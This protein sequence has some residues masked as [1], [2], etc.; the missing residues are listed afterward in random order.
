MLSRQWENGLVFESLLPE[1]SQD[2]VGF[3]TLSKNESGDDMITQGIELM[4]TLDLFPYEDAE[5][6]MFA[7]PDEEDKNS[8][9][10]P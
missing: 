8:E 10:G 7:P 3:Y 5:M 4:N 6:E 1:I 2:G 9:L